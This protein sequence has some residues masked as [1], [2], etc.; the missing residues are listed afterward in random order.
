MTGVGFEVV[1]A[2]PGS[3]WK[4]H[5]YDFMSCASIK[6][7]WKG[8]RWGEEWLLCPDASSFRFTAQ[9]W[10]KIKAV[11]PEV[12]K[13]NTTQLHPDKPEPPTDRGMR[14]EM[15]KRKNGNEGGSG[16][17]YRCRKKKNT[18]GLRRDWEVERCERRAVGRRRCC[19]EAVEG[20]G[21]DRKKKVKLSTSSGE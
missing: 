2:E 20:G 15:K 4:I 16:A 1:M 3:K 11:L 21:W 17:D 12:F 6:R 5:G 10:L 19:K 9:V 13:H 8:I 7:I 14:R 18:K